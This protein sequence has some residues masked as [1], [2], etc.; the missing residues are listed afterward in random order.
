MAAGDFDGDGRADLAVGVPL[1]GIENP[2]DQEGAVNV[3]YGTAR[4]LSVTGDQFFHQNTLGIKGIA[5]Y[6]DEFGW[7]LASR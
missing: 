1:E 4:G 6:N 3:V 2:H 7:S 5:E